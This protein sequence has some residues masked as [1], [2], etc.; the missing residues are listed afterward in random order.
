MRYK[1]RNNGGVAPAS[2]W[3]GTKR[4]RREPACKPGSVGDSHSS[5]T[6]VTVRLL[7]PTRE[8]CG[9]HRCS[10]IWSCSGWGLP[11]RG[12]LPPARCAL[13]APFH[14]CLIRVSPAIGGLFSVALS[15]GSRPP[16]VTWH[17][18]LRSPDFPPWPWGHSGC[19]AGFNQQY[20]ALSA[21]CK[22]EPGFSTVRAGQGVNL[23]SPKYNINTACYIVFFIQYLAREGAQDPRRA[24]ALRPSNPQS[25]RRCRPVILHRGAWHRSPGP[26]SG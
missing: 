24:R 12:V 18:A 10:P 6:D 20:G 17:P 8:R 7:R 5:G 2:V 25:S 11:C 14:P 4:K 26:A 16:G 23:F 21:G 3:R 1:G 22:C 9:P 19:P 13:T 15:V